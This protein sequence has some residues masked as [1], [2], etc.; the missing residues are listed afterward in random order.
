VAGIAQDIEGLR[1]NRAVAQ[2]YELTN[3]LA[4]ARDG[5][6]SGSALSALREGVKSLIQLINPMMPHLAESC[7]EVLGQDGLVSDALWP[8]VDPAMLVDDEV[9][10]PIQINGKRRGEITVAKGMAAADV[11]ALVLALDV[12]QKALDGKTPK[13]VVVVQDRIVNIVV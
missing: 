12:V 11:E 1:F 9:T 3:V 7:W 13:K 10:L 8:E 6:P 5:K 2:I 4:K